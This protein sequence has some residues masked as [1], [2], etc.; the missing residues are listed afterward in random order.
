MPFLDSDDRPFAPARSFRIVHFDWDSPN[1][2]G[3]WQTG[4]HLPV[5]SQGITWG[6]FEIR[7]FPRLCSSACDCMRLNC[8]QWH[9]SHNNAFHH[10]LIRMSYF[11]AYSDIQSSAHFAIRH[12][13][14]LDSLH[15]DF[16]PKKFHRPDC[17]TER[18]SSTLW[19]GRVFVLLLP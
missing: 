7:L 10:S 15:Q 19:V 11:D 13:T 16:K 5:I 6:E 4:R 8:G 17:N 3:S 2:K 14:Y 9:E 1:A 12:G 18:W